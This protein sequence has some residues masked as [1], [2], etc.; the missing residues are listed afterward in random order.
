MLGTERSAWQ[1]RMCPDA[2]YD[3]ENF[4]DT[5]WAADIHITPDGRLYTPATVP[6]V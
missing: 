3:A 1:Y 2:G 4:S 5:R 6:P